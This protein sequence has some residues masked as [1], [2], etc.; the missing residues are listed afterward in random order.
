MI[1][2]VCN[3]VTIDGGA[4]RLRC[5]ACGR[6]AHGTAGPFRAAYRRLVAAAQRL[7]FHGFG[8]V[9][10]DLY[11]LGAAIAVNEFTM[12]CAACRRSTPLSPE[13]LE[14]VAIAPTR[15]TCD[16]CGRRP[17]PATLAREFAAAFAGARRTERAL[18]GFSWRPSCMTRAR[19]G[20]RTR[21]KGLRG[22]RGG[23]TRRS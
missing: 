10:V 5:A 13:F 20:R 19:G 23:I 16:H 7:E 12:R 6:A 15:L 17:R 22:G 1:C 18:R 9:A 3:A 14:T 4:G 21:R 11:R 8:F 2:E